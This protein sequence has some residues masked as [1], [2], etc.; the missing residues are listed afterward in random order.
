MRTM[1]IVLALALPVAVNAKGAPPKAHAFQTAKVSVKAPT[2]SHTGN[3]AADA[4]IDTQ[5]LRFLQADMKADGG[6]GK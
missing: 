4:K 3:E 1:L 5:M 2:P 6:A